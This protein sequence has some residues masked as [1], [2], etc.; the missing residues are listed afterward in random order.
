MSKTKPDIYRSPGA[1]PAELTRESMKIVPFRQNNECVYAVIS[2]RAYR[3]IVSETTEHGADE[4]GGILLGHFLNG[5]WYI[6]EAVDP[7]INTVNQHSYFEYDGKYVNHLCSKLSKI[8]NYPL[9]ILGI[10]HRHPGSFDSFSSTDLTSMANITNDARVGIL[11]ML[12]NVDPQLRMTFYFCSKRG[13]VMKIPCDVGDAYFPDEIIG[14]AEPDV[15]CERAEPG[16]TVRVTRYLLPEELRRINSRYFESARRNISYSGAP[17]ADEEVKPDV[18]AAEKKA[19]SEQTAAEKRPSHG[20]PAIEAEVRRPERTAAPNPAEKHPGGYT[21]AAEWSVLE[22]RTRP[23]S[24]FMPKAPALGR[25]ALFSDRAWDT[26]VTASVRFGEGGVLLGHISGNTASVVECVGYHRSSLRQSC[27]RLEN[28][29]TL[30][31]ICDIYKERLSVIGC[32][33]V[34][35]NCERLGDEDIDCVD[36][37][38]AD[39]TQVLLVKV[40]V[41]RGVTVCG[42]FGDSQHR[43]IRTHEC[44]GSKYISGEHLIGV[45]ARRRVYGTAP[46]SFVRVNH[47]NAFGSSFYPFCEYTAPPAKVRAAKPVRKARTA[48]E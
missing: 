29:Y 32:W 5:I 45:S 34:A 17:S 41:G 3:S 40:G 15:I 24:V 25:Y 12:V 11:S 38:A 30:L 14:Y 7:G 6:V 10:W 26:M 46:G 19:Q 33:Y 4:T 48:A 44:V 9:T 16:V 22:R 8:Y 37:L 27:S 42:F 36:R 28:E 20:E 21:R 43:L 39:G 2:D 1:E 13:E 18:P 35:E 23:G 31:S 47:R